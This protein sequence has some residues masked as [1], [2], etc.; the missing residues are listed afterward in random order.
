MLGGSLLAYAVWRSCAAGTLSS[1]FGSDLTLS[2]VGLYVLVAADGLL[3]CPCRV[4]FRF[5]TRCSP[6]HTAQSGAVFLCL[7]AEWFRCCRGLTAALDT[8]KRGSC[9][10]VRSFLFRGLAAVCLT[11]FA[12]AGAVAA[13]LPAFK[14]GFIFTTHHSPFL[15]AA[16]QGEAFRDLGVYLKPLVERES[17]ELVKD[18]KPLAILDLVVA[19]S[20]SETA[21]LFAQKHLDMGIASITAIMAGIDKGTPMKIVCPLQTEG[22][23]LVVPSASTLTNWDDLLKRVRDSKEPVK[24]GF[25]SPTSAPKIVLEG[26]LVQAGLK[27]TLDPADTKADVLLVDLKETSNLLA[28]LTAGQVEAVVGPSPFPEVAQTRGVGKVLVA[29]NDLP[30][31]GQ[32]ANFPCCVGV[33]SQDMIDKHPEVVRAFVAL[34]SRAGEWCNAHPRQAGEMAAQW[35]GLPPEA[36]SKSTLVFLNSFTDSWLRGADT[37][38][39]ILDGMHKFSGSLAGRTLQ[40]CRG[41]LI[42]DAFLDKGK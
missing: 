24:I 33:A 15:V 4:R 12:A 31:A 18:G 9:L 25:H 23:A 21:T 39:R 20:G 16:S 22:M 10:M 26:A 37:Y 40:Q 11:L 34:I 27:V 41:Q 32:W 6:P 3:T 30:P 17:Y 2:V 29:L 38:L 8:I 36:G 19:K 35:I 42:N 1:P 7:T 14:T 13:E 28:A 5:S